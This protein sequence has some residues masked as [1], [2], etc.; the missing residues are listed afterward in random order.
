MARMIAI[1]MVCVSLL[2]GGCSGVTD[3]LPDLGPVPDGVFMTDATGYVARRIPD[4][5]TVPRYRFTVI[6]R[7]ENRGTAS[8]FLGRC[9]PTS[10]QPVFSVVAAGS[11]VRS[12][13]EYV[14]ACVGHDKQ[15]EVPPSAVRVDTLHV[16]G[17]NTFDGVTHQAIGVTSGR[18]KLLFT[19][20]L[21]AGDGV[22]GA[23][24]PVRLSNEFLVRT[25]D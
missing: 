8:L 12:G 14:W 22:P 2:P 16:E 5:G 9:F 6:T 21:V 25:S 13:Y 11:S 3:P 10:P 1:G 23:P 24:L 15:F 19:V 17:P 7:Y 18:F 4:S 20:G